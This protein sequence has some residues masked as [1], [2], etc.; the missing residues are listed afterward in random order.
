LGD[1]EEGEPPFEPGDLA[2]DLP[3][4][5]GAHQR[6]FELARL[7]AEHEAGGGARWRS[8]ARWTWRTRWALFWTARPSRRLTR[9]SGW[10]G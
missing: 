1:L 6:R 10:T 9:A 3:P 8:R 2:L 5:I 4:A 7:A